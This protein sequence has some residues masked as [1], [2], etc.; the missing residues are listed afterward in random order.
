MALC[1]TRE[2][3]RMND[4][5][6]RH[7]R[8]GN[9]PKPKANPTK[10][11]VATS[12]HLTFLIAGRDVSIARRPYELFAMR[13][14]WL[15]W[16]LLFC[17]W[18]VIGLAFASQLYLSRAKIGDPVS[19]RFALGRSL[20]DWYVF[21]ILSL[22]ASWLARRFPLEKQTWAS[23]FFLHLGASALFSLGW[24]VLR[25]WVEQWESGGRPMSFAATL[26]H[27]LVAT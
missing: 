12:G 6:Y 3:S 25:A 11:E 5:T 23:A 18:T 9:V 27:A 7:V 17:L 1:S 14:Q 24:M 22:P 13:K 16:V 26:S 20:A 10:N 2:D 8:I 4:V 21:A 15:K 19:W